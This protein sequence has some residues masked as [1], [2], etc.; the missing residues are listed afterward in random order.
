MENEKI[1]LLA[2]SMAGYICTAKYKAGT[3]NMCADLLL[4]KT[5][6]IHAEA[7]AEPFE[8]NINDNTFEVG[9]I[10]SNEINCKQYASCE[11]GDNPEK[12][13]AN[14]GFD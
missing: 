5:D 4:C 11:V 3:E 9:V 13:G 10:N 2:L 8:V 12:R 7:E 1:Q 14:L 6:G